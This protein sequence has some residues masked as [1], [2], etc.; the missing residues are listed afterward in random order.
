MDIPLIIYRISGW[1][2]SLVNIFIAYTAIKCKNLWQG[3]HMFIGAYMCWL[4]IANLT[5]GITALFNINNLFIEHIPVSFVLKA[6]YLKGQHKS[7]KVHYF[8]YLSI[9]IYVFAQIYKAFDHEGYKQMNALGAYS[10]YPFIIIYTVWNLTILF[11][12]KPA[13]QILRK[14]ADFWFTATMFCLAFFSLVS[15]ILDDISYVAN[16]NMVLY[17]LF[18]SENFI[19]SFLF[20]G[21]YRGIKLLR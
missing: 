13:S 20:Y 19:N 11:R 16:S 4:A 15:T 5:S 14:N 1:T 6:L 9:I 12:E 7:Q 3:R 18:I 17:V 2:H 21:Y 10:G 8:T